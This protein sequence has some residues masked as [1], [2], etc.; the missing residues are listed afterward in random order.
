MVCYVKAI[1]NK[2]EKKTTSTVTQR[3]EYCIFTPR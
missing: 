1:A 2:M 3:G